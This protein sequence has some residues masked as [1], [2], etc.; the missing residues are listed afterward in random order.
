MDRR[1]RSRI[2]PLNN[3]TRSDAVQRAFHL[4]LRQLITGEDRNSRQIVLRQETSYELFA[5][6]ARSLSIANRGT[7]NNGYTQPFVRS[8]GA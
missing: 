2:S 3:R 5:E 7:I 4:E 1:S 6:G 8:L